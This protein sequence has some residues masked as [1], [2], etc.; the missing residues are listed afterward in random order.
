MVGRFVGAW[1]M[2]WISEA[3]LLAC[4]A[5]MAVALTMGA[6]LLPGAL[7]AAALIAVGLCNAIMY[8]TIYAL[9]LPRDR[10]LAPLASMWLC[11]A[12]VGG[13]VVPMLTGV[14]ADRVGLLPAL[15]L[16]A[17]C[18]VG[19]GGFAIACGWSREKDA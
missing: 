9:A 1:L 15:L 16:P 10:Q 19:I 11:M 2:T 7:G 13:A 4:A 12:V 3:G 6:A 8:P 14:V 17:I 5:A 18:Y